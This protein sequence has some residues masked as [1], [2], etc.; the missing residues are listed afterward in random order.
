MDARKR[1]RPRREDAEREVELAIMRTEVR[2][3]TRGRT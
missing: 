3:G 2:K 1:L